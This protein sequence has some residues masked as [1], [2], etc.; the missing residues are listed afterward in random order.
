M[1]N[2][3]DDA[4]KI[5]QQAQDKGWADDAKNKLDK[6]FGDNKQ[7]DQKPNENQQSNQQ[8]GGE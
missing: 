7:K 4:K 6:K 8:N 3:M 2:F 1:V 5:E